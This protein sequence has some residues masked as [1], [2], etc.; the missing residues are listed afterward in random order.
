MAK[1]AEIAGPIRQTRQKAGWA[2]ILNLPN[3]ENPSNLYCR[4]AGHIT[5]LSLQH[6]VTRP[7]SFWRCGAGYMLCHRYKQW[8]LLQYVVSQV[9]DDQ[10]ICVGYD[11]AAKGAEVGSGECFGFGIP[12][13]QPFHAYLFH[14]FNLQG[15][16]DKLNSTPRAATWFEEK[17]EVHFQSKGSLEPGISF[18]TGMGEAGNALLE[19]VDEAVLLEKLLREAGCID[20]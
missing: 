15:S 16:L 6:F 8:Q 9:D 7:A 18:L 10:K 20:S 17:S 13:L 1:W 2:R 4:I 3:K 12:C 19:V 5:I 11:G 14:S